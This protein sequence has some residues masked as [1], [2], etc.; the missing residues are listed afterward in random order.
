MSD[1]SVNARLGRNFA[2][3][4]ANHNK[5]GSGNRFAFVDLTGDN[6]YTDYGLR[7]LRGNGGQNNGTVFYHRGTGEFRV[8]AITASGASFFT[9]NTE[10]L[11]V[12]ADGVLNLSPGNLAGAVQP[13][14]C[15]TYN[16]TTAATVNNNIRFE[17]AVFNYGGHYNTANGVFTAPIAGRYFFRFHLL[18]NNPTTGVTQIHLVRNGAVTA[19]SAVIV[20]HPANTWNTLYCNIVFNMAVNDTASVFVGLLPAAI[21]TDALFDS[22]SGYLLI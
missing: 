21:H 10:R 1:A 7:F 9:N 15:A 16:G 22:F 8:E 11:R 2:N 12:G 17:T 14:F 4:A 20:Q 18:P 3:N 5:T 13:A 19:G 6:T